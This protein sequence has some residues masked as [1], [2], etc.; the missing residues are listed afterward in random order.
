MQSDGPELPR[1]YLRPSRSHEIRALTSRSEVRLGELG[2]LIQ[3]VMER[4]VVLWHGQSYHGSP[5]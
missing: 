1:R 2:A 4:L 5:R 3:R